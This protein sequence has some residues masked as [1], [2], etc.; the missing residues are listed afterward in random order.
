MRKVSKPSNKSSKPSNKPSEPSG[1][2]NKPSEPN[3]KHTE[4]SN[5]P[6]TCRCGWRWNYDGLREAWIYIIMYTE[7]I[8]EDKDNQLGDSSSNVNFP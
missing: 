3:N 8:H 1:P 2:S 7:L 6:T 5:K 4:P